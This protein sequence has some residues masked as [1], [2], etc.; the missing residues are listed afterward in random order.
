METMVCPR[1]NVLFFII[2]N[3]SKDI[4]LRNQTPRVIE[5]KKGTK[6]MKHM[7]QRVKKLKINPCMKTLIND[8][9]YGRTWK[10]P[11]FL[12]SLVSFLIRR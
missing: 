1:L 6:E 10:V 9:Y 2:F 7:Q 5:E 4:F 3:T 11:S 12:S 8:L